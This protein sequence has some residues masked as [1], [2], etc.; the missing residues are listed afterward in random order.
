MEERV[1]VVSAGPV[2]DQAGKR[3]LC[4]SDGSGERIDASLTDDQIRVRFNLDRVTQ[5]PKID[6]CEGLLL[7][8]PLA[9]TTAYAVN[10]LGFLVQLTLPPRRPG[11]PV[12]TYEVV[13]LS[14]DDRPAELRHAPEAPQK[15]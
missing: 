12:V 6:F 9:G 10:E 11:G 5:A 8:G 3:W 1:G 14:T 4:I 7:D 2:G 15:S 13:T